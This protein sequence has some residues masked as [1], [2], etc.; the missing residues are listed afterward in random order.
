MTTRKR[1]K[2]YKKEEA[3]IYFVCFFFPQSHQPYLRCRRQL[4]PVGALDTFLPF[5]GGSDLTTINQSKPR[6]K[7]EKKNPTFDLIDVRRVDRRSKHLHTDALLLRWS[8]IGFNESVHQG[9]KWLV[10]WLV[11]RREL[12]LHHVCLCSF[13]LQDYSSPS[14]S[15]ITGGDESVGILWC[16]DIV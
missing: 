15:T 3:G 8:G 12:S 7:K 4:E 6:K 2:T 14:E 1:K 16:T 5:V 10:G 11:M 9:E 13:S